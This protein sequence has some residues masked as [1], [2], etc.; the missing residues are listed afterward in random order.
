MED[1]TELGSE[2]TRIM[3]MKLPKIIEGY[4]I[5][6]G[7]G[8]SGATGFEGILHVAADGKVAKQSV[9]S[10]AAPTLAEMQGFTQRIIP[11][12]RS[13][14]EWYM[15][16]AMWALIKGST[17][18]VSAANIGLQVID[19]VN[20]RLLGYPVNVVESMPATNPILFGDASQYTLVNG[21]GGQVMLFSRELGLLSDQVYWR[22]TKRVGGCVACAKYTLADNSTV[23]AFCKADVVA[24]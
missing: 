9:A 19:F 3:T 6:S 20:D 5:C 8:A 4:A 13:K 10:I 17:N 14:S 18:F 11:A 12:F 2:I 21:R 23:A 22:L 16:N 15:S 24:S 7:S 1:I